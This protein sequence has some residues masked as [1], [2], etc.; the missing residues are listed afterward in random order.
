MSYKI[1]SLVVAITPSK[2]FHEKFYFAATRACPLNTH[3]P[4]LPDFPSTTYQNSKIYTKL[5]QNIPNA[6]NKCEMAAHYYK[7]PQKNTNIFHSKALE[8]IPK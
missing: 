8:N 4:G 5:P 1:Y 6:H 3:T 2:I 7:F